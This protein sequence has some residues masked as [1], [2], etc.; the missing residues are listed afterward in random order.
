MNS[1]SWQIIGYH[2]GSEIHQCHE[3]GVETM[4]AVPALSTEAPD[5]AY[6]LE[7]FIYNKDTDTYQYPEGNLLHTNG[8]W[9]NKENDYRIK[10]YINPPEIRFPGIL[11]LLF[12][13]KY[14]LSIFL[15]YFVTLSYQRKVREVF[16]RTLVINN[17]F[18]NKIT[19]CS[20]RCTKNHW[21]FRKFFKYL[22]VIKDSRFTKEPTE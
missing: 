5:P 17:Q 14:I 3:M 6:D 4:V 19:S 11:E 15:K 21:I 13:K 12:I 1:L 10:Q 22:P 20:S 8:S 7:Q 16:R 2:T 18:V 9:Y